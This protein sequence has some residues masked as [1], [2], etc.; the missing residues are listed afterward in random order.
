MRDKKVS[1][2][3]VIE[4]VISEEKSCLELCSEE[5]IPN[6]KVVR[7]GCWRERFG[8]DK[9]VFQKGATTRHIIS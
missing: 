1:E 9:L 6:K 8:N 7:V 2:M 5:S 4:C 3:S